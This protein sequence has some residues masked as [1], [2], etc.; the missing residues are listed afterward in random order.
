MT[1]EYIYKVFSINRPEEK[2]LVIEMLGKIKQTHRLS[3]EFEDECSNYLRVLHNLT[4]DLNKNEIS[5]KNQEKF[6][7]EFIE[8]N[9]LSY[10]YELTIESKE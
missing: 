8:L 6:I 5:E 1:I 10:E 3:F 4:I 7:N 9:P 2:M